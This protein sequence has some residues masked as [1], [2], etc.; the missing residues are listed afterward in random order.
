MNKRFFSLI[1]GK[2]I[3]IAP[4]TKIIPA[5]EFSTLL[6]AKNIL[7]QAKE[8]AENYK[9]KIA[10]DCEKIKAQAE[11]DGFHKGFEEWATHIAQLETEIQNVRKE[12]EKAIV[13]IA[14]KAA[15]KIVGKE[16]E[17]SEETIVDIVLNYLKAV[18]AHKQITIYVSKKD[19]NILEMN[20][21]RLKDMFESL[22]VLSI[23]ERPD[24]EPG[25][26]I[27]ETEGGIINA[28][29]ENQWTLMEKAFK[30]MMKENIEPAK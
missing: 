25:G 2:A 20:R 8:D 13:P 24:I 23:R 16:I 22:E 27:I 5:V 12:S 18:S 11:L 15:K 19:L 4:K 7:E 6:D 28:K 29:L 3:H 30:G 21:N 26:C 9:M 1:N 14:L 10:I 17:L